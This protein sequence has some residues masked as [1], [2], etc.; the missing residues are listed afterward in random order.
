MSKNLIRMCKTALLLFCFASYGCSEDS[1]E[2]E[3]MEMPDTGMTPCLDCPAECPAEEEWP[4]GFVCIPA[5]EFWMG[6]PEGQIPR[7]EQNE[8]RHRVQISNAYFIGISEVTQDEWSEVVSSNPAFFSDSG[9]GCELEP[10]N[11][12][13]VERLSWN[14]AVAYTN[15]RSEME[16]L[17]PCYELDGCEGTLGGGCDRDASTCRADFVC[18]DVQLSAQCNGYR[19]PTEAEW[20]YAA[21]G[22]LDEYRYGP[23]DEIAWYLGTARS[24]TRPGGGKDANPYGL[25]DIYGNVAEWVY[26]RFAA[27]YG[28]FLDADTATV[29]PRG[30]DEGNVSVRVIRGGSWQD[31]YEACRAAY[32]YSAFPGDR[33]NAIGFRLVKQIK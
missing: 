20:E 29:D 26:D 13:P 8:Q 15:A 17:T 24:R 9:N 22:G 6:S 23:V 18:S 21:R 2:T 16:G 5:G 12:R 28:F 11:I 7:N 33:S 3:P 10:C 25:N 32:R 1:A 27:D 4:A 14:E 31:G 19:L 30:P